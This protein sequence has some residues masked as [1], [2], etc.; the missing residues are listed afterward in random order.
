LTLINVTKMPKNTKKDTT[1][2]GTLRLNIKPL[3]KLENEFLPI[4]ILNFATKIILPDTVSVN[5]P[6]TIFILY[7]PR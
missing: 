6:I 2:A 1:D 3:K 5:N 4:E 7:F